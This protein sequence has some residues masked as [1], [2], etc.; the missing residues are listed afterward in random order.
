MASEQPQ[1][2]NEKRIARKMMMR[3]EIE[4][5]QQ[6]PRRRSTRCSVDSF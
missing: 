2:Q 4:K 6:P 1:V 3:I 5:I